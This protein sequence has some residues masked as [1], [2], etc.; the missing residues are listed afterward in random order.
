MA[1]FVT[2]I[3]WVVKLVAKMDKE[4]VQ[5]YKSRQQLATH[6]DI[7]RPHYSRLILSTYFNTRIQDFNLVLG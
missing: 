7:A 3:V 6:F 4:T 1:K 5:V 2:P